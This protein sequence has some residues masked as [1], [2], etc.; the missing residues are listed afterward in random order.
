MN[1]K[2]EEFYSQL[3]QVPF[4]ADHHFECFRFKKQEF[5]AF[6]TTLISKKDQ[7][8]TCSFN[9][10]DEY[11]DI[12]EIDMQFFNKCTLETLKII[13]DKV[14]KKF[15][16]NIKVVENE[17][18]IEYLIYYH[19]SEIEDVLDVFFTILDVFGHTSTFIYEK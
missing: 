7:K 13:G 14:A 16:K 12:V 6:A 4:I 8:I 19:L 9:I 1:P 11:P 5:T 3:Y 17:S 18:C 10:Y 2:T 15:N